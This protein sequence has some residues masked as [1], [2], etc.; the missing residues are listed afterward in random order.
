[1]LANADKRGGKS[2]V[3][4][5]MKKTSA[6]QNLT[7]VVNTCDAYSDVVKIF[8]LALADYW[9]DCPYPVVINTETNK[10]SFQARVNNYYSYNGLDDWGDR[11]RS[12]LGNVDT[13]FVLMVFDDFV[14]NSKVCN[15]RLEDALEIIQSQ[16]QVAVVYLNNTS[17]PLKP[18]RSSDQFVAIRDKAHFRLNSFP[19]IWRKKTLMNYTAVGDTPWA[20]E[21]F[22]SYRTWG[23][24]QLFYSLNPNYSDIYPY[25]NIKGGAIYRG[26]WVKEVVHQ[27][28][29]R[30][31]LDI[32]WNIRGF[33]S[34]EGLEKRSW[35]WRFRFMQTGFRMV[36]FRSFNYLI[37]YIKEKLH[38]I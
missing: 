31:N 18:I 15:Q 10:Y 16:V 17:L 34:D 5:Y 21:A 2:L 32:D 28:S 26:K 19:A 14:L 33:S 25:N 27:V 36:G 29:E 23:D 30:Y 8:F 1:V 3:K 4:N 9:P 13:D 37:Y 38:A 12:T 11:L 35:K 7:I 24:K 6:S 20:W 22:G